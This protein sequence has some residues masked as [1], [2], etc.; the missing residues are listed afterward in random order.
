MSHNSPVSVAT[1]RR[2]R[3]SLSCLPRGRNKTYGYEEN[4]EEVAWV[5]PVTTFNRK[6][7]AF[8]S[9]NERF[10]ETN[11]AYGDLCLFVRIGKAGERLSYPRIS[12][13]DLDE[14]DEDME[15]LE[16]QGSKD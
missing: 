12:Q 8:S 13:G 1:M 4:V 9:P 14:E 5:T 11:V 10:T 16:S 6:E 3:S 2:S 15:D 7:S